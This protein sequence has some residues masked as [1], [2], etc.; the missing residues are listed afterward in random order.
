ML[1][2]GIKSNIELSGGSSV[3]FTLL[4]ETSEKEDIPVAVEVGAW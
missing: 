1:A 4:N 3:V 2:C